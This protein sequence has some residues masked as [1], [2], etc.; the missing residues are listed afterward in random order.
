MLRYV[1]LPL[2]YLGVPI[3]DL[4]FVD[5]TENPTRQLASS[6]ELQPKHLVQPEIQ[7]T[8]PHFRPVSYDQC[9]EEAFEDL[10]YKFS[11]NS[12]IQV[13]RH[14][15]RGNIIGFEYYN[16]LTLSSKA[17]TTMSKSPPSATKTEE[18]ADLSANL[19][20]DVDTTQPTTEILNVLNQLNTDTAPNSQESIKVEQQPKEEVPQQPQLSEWESLRNRLRDSPHDP[21]GWSKLVDLAENSGEMEKIKDTYESLL[22]IYPNTV[23]QSSAFRLLFSSDHC[24][25]LS[26]PPRSHISIII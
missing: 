2:V 5:L 10:L 12:R 7:S 6:V 13:Q 4:R 21:E 24:L 26:H 20:G 1:L 14:S 9:R 23:C 15:Q 22:Q 16:A 3:P 18:S 25:I 19:S 17:R 8:V 11:F